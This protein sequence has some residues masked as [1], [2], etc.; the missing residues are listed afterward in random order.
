MCA[1]RAIC[2][3]TLFL[4]LCGGGGCAKPQKRVEAADPRPPSS[5]CYSR[6]QHI[7]HPERKAF[8]LARHT[9][10]PLKNAA[11]EKAKTLAV[12]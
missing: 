1:V 12:C 10:N 9:E 3:V 5:E 11:A 6:K 7:S 2:Y 8:P 4:A